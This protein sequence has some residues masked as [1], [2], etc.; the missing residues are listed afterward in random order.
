MAKL[1]GSCLCG[2]VTYSCAAEPLA[3]AVCHCTDCQKQTGTTFSIIVAVPREALDIDW[4]SLG[5]FTT[6][7]TDS[8][9]EVARH[10]CRNCGSPVAS[11][12][13]A[14]PTMALI[15]GGT[16]DD[17]SWLEPQMHVWTESA[18]DWLPIDE[19]AG[20]KLPRGP[21]S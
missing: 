3:T 18:Q 4:D 12:A 8:G 21:G 5:S 11:I 19:H 14:M 6:V 2:K 1:D 7:G 13:E 15:K 17:T 10:F 20:A 16:L 9:Q